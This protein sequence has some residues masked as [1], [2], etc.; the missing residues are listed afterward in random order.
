MI[1]CNQSRRPIR[2][3]V[4]QFG[5]DQHGHASVSKR[6]NP[7]EDARGDYVFVIV[8]HRESISR[9]ERSFKNTDDVIF[10]AGAY[11]RTLFA[12]GAYDELIVSNNARLGSRGPACIDDE[13]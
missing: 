13:I 9:F 3:E 2:S 7:L 8:G 5:I 1:G 10:G 6:E 11:G 4:T 12:I